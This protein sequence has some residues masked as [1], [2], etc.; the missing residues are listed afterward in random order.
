MNCLIS[1]S[2]HSCSQ[3]SVAAHVSLS[4]PQQKMK[5]C[6]QALYKKWELEN[7]GEDKTSELDKYL[8]EAN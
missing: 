1:I 6:I 3:S 2:L 4:E 8:N 7:G 5:K